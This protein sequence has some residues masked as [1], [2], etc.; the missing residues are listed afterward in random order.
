MKGSRT[1]STKVTPDFAALAFT[2]PSRRRK[3][4]Q[5]TEHDAEGRD[6]CDLNEDQKVDPPTQLQQAKA[7]GTPRAS[8]PVSVLRTRQRARSLRSFTHRLFKPCCEMLLNF[9]QAPYFR[10]DITLSIW[11]AW[12]HFSVWFLISSGAIVDTGL[13]VH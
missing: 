2:T 1:A 11:H 9:K 7:R 3:L 10:S 12:T 6:G 13:Y 4:E 8:Q 5:L